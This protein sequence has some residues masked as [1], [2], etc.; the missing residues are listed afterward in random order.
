MLL[1]IALLLPGC[2]G[3]L[4]VAGAATGVA[5]AYDRRTAGTVVEDQNIEFKAAAA[6]R[7]DKAL[8]D[9]AHIGVV[10][11]NNIVL[12]VGQAPTKALRDRA[13]ALARKVEKVRRV[14]NEIALGEPIP[15]S[16]RNRDIWITTKVKSALLGSKGLEAIHVKV[17][18]EDGVVYLMGLLT[19]REA[20]D[21]A[22]RVQQVKGVK[23]VVK[24][25]EYLD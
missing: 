3:G 6:I 5:V 20:E 1:I 15:F 23:R 8:R 21:V 11:Y 17:V 18:T 9:K 25:F 16:V 2:T 4:I 7:R 22:R 12:L 13:A 10:S 24:V 19:R 14:H